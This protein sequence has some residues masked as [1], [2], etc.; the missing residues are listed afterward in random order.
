MEKDKIHQV[1][2]SDA[3]ETWQTYID[4]IRDSI[5]KNRPDNI[6]DDEFWGIH[7][8][9]GTSGVLKYLIRL[10]REMFVK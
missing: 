7:K 9:R 5:L 3:R 10:G 2:L 4:N 8:K 1:C 6:T